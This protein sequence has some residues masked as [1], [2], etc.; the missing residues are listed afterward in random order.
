MKK[1]MKLEQ[2][3]AKNITRLMETTTGLDTIDKV[4]QR[5]GVGRGTVDRVR[6]AE[7]STKIETVELLAAAFGVSPLALLSETWPPAA[8]AVEEHPPLAETNVATRRVPTSM[9]WVSPEEDELLTDFRT[10]DDEGRRTMKNIGSI[11]PKTL[12]S[13]IGKNKS[14]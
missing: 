8:A 14:E 12:F 9:Q 3:L 10:T 11:V 7:V 2:I 4:A 13:L 1:T 6:K 5:S